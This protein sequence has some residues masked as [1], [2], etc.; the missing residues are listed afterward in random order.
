MTTTRQAGKMGWERKKAKYGDKIK[1]VQTRAASLG[2]KQKK[3]NQDKKL[4][5]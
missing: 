2:G 3:I 5:L 1:E 4:D